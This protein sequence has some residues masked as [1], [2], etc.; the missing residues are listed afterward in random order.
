MNTLLTILVHLWK[1]PEWLWG[2]FLVPGVLLL[3]LL[4][5]KRRR[6]VLR[7]IG[8]LPLLTGFVGLSR[9]LRWLRATVLS[10]ALGFAA[11]AAARPQWGTVTEL[12]RSRGLDVAIL[13]DVSMSMLAQDIP[14]NRL[15]AA[16]HE[17][18]T[19]LGQ[20]TGDRVALVP[21]AGSA[22]VQCPL[23]LDYSAAKL[24]LDDVNTYSIPDE[25]TAIGT[26]IRVGLRAFGKDTDQERVMVLITDGEDHGSD[27]LGA[28][29]EAAHQGVRIYTIGFGSPDGELIP[30]VGQDGRTEFL[31]DDEG[32][33]VKTRLDEPTLQRIAVETGGKYYRSTAGEMELEGILNDVSALEGAAHAE[34]QLVS[35][36]DRYQWPLAVSV[37]LLLVVPFI[38]ERRGPS[39]RTN[40][41]GGRR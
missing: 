26:A 35:R 1:E 14:P 19:F 2:L 37:I 4:V 7:R 17:I 10:L 20:L 21:F 18:A 29:Q 39:G 15:A 9:A 36:V 34:Q 3:F 25:G 31:R 30:Q 32:R 41:A 12:V 5:Q 40:A 38:P 28:A 22:F 8:S 16:K 11:L 13:L 6:S 33:I 23:T 27:P 24:F